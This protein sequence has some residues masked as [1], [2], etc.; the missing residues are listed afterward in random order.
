MSNS[1]PGANLLGWEKAEA[2][3]WAT[4]PGRNSGQISFHLALAAAFSKED[5]FFSPK[6]ALFSHSYFLCFN[7]H[8]PL[9]KQPSVVAKKLLLVSSTLRH[10]GQLVAAQLSHAT[11]IIQPSTF[12]GIRTIPLSCFTDQPKFMARI[13]TTHLSTHVRSN[14]PQQFFV[15]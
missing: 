7:I 5:F 3:G 4:C 15:F 8:I 12:L 10:F 6:N 14:T 9:V 13:L 1:S 2:V 11:F